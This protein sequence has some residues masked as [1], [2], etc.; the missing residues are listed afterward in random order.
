MENPF[1]RE[2]MALGSGAL[3][4]LKA[5]H[6]AVFGIGGVGSYVAEALAGQASAR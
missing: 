5:S 1:I 4:K 3:E 6:V 2:E